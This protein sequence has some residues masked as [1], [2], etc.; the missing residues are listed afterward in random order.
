MGE[1]TRVV[2]GRG[3]KE[4]I[5]KMITVFEEDKTGRFYKLCTQPLPFWSAACIRLD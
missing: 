5:T 3:Q 1:G 4:K 2:G